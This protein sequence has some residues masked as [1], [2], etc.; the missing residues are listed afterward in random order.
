MPWT[1]ADVDSHKK[2]LTEKQKKQWVRIANSVLKTCMKKE[3]AVEADCAAAAIKQANGV[4]INTNKGKEQYSTYKNKQVLDYEVKLVVHQDKPHLVVPVVMMVEGVRNGSAGPILHKIAELGKFPETWN[5][6]PVVIYHPEEDGQP[7]SANSPEIIDNIAVGKVYNTTVDGK[8]LKAE[9]WIDEDK[10]N[11]VSKETLA[12]INETTEVEVSLG[13]FADYLDEEG[14][15]EGEKYSKIAMNHRPDHLAILPDQIGACSCK[16][17]CGLGANQNNKNMP[18]VKTLI[19]QNQLEKTIQSF[20]KEGFRLSQIGN[21]AQ[22]GYNELMSLVNS[23]LRKMDTD[24]EV[25]DV[26]IYTWHYLEELYDDS[27]VYTKS[28]NK[29]DSKMYKQSYKLES[30]KIEF[31]G[32]PVEVHKKVEYIVNSSL[33]N[34][35]SSI[36][37]KLEDKNMPK[38]EC[39]KC[40]EK[41]NAVI[42]NKESGFVEADREWLETLSEAAL[43]KTIT[44]KV[45][46]VEKTVE[47]NKLTAEQQADLAYA[48]SMRKEK[49]NTLVQG[50]QANTSKEL[51]P[52]AELEALSDDKLDRLYKSVVKEE[53]TT[54]YTLNASGFQNNSGRSG[55]GGIMTPPG[56]EIEN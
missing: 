39:P 2:G 56:V 55:S 1:V 37:N 53:T 10:L 31:T 54:N 20:N 11:S 40:L 13:M 3:G 18:E 43:D 22:Q 19:Q 34:H 15:F 5:G 51:W 23:A 8:K 44:P 41:I 36:N 45:K 42:A 32:E 50:I 46:E 6:I 9:V 16:D 14:E 48:Q 33:A 21:Y 28:G 49:R 29:I 25:D 17:G 4:V 35:K 38:N 47:V 26:R 12:N 7:V 52:D 24:E 27:L 30:G